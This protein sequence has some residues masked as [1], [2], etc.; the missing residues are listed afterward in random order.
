[1]ARVHRRTALGRWTV[2]LAGLLLV[3][4]V[5]LARPSIAVAAPKGASDPATK[6][7]PRG[8]GGW[9]PATP[10]K[11]TTTKYQ[12]S[13]GTG[14]P[15]VL[16]PDPNAKR[17][18]ELTDKRTANTSSFRMSDG[19]V[20]Q[21]VSTLPTH[22]RDVKGAWQSI[23]PTVKPL[24]HDGFTAGSQANSFQ[25]YFSPDA[26][27]LVRID[28]GG[29][30]VQIAAD[31][32]TTGAP[33][34]TGS[35]VSYPGA[36]PGA[37][38]DYQV[39]PESLKQT[40]VLAKAPA[41]DQSYSFTLKLG[42]GLVPQQLPDG[43]IALHSTETNSPVFT[44]P[45]PYMSDAKGD[46][47]SPYGKVYST[48]VSQSMTFD[49]GTATAHVTVK[50]DAAWLADP[51]R[52]YPV[53]I[54]PTILVSPTPSTSANTMILADSPTTNY[55]TSWRLSVGTTTTGAGR[56]LIKF[57]LP[58]IPAGTTITS[59][60]LG[61]YYD[62]T[63]TDGSRDV[64]MQALQANASW[65]ATT[66]TWS[67][68]NSI[69][70]P[71]A[72]TSTMPGNA[73]DVWNHFPVTSAVQAWVNGSPNNG[74]VIKATNEAALGLGGPRFEGSIYA[75]GGEVV[76]Y[77]KLTITYGAP[78]VSVDAPT[79]I[80]ATG[81]ELS[82][83]GYT[84]T[85]GDSANDMVE[86][87]VHR[88]VFQ[89]FT[90]SQDTLVSPV[91]TTTSRT[92]VDST[93]VPT[94]AASSDPYGNAYYYMVAVKTKGGKLIAGPTQLVRLPKAGRTTVLIPATAATTLSSTQPTAVLNTLNNGGTPE[95]WLEVGDNS[96][97]YG[98]ARSVFDFGQL[99]QVP[100]GSKI[101]DA[102]LKVWQETTTTNTSGAVYELHSL[103]RS[104]TGN[105]ATWNSPATGTAWTAAGGDFTSAAAGTVSG[106]TN[107]PNRQNF[108]ATAIVQGWITTAG[109]NHG[110]LVKLKAETSKSAQERTI[111]A[112]TNTADPQLAP[113]LVV[114]YLDTSAGTY[115]A[116][117][118]PDKM[119]PGT[120]YT[121]PVTV[122]NTSGSTWTAANERL[123]YHWDLP[124]G[125]DVT[126]TGNQ[127]TTALPADLAP[128][129]TATINAQVTPPTPA[130]SNAKGQYTLAWDMKNASNG[131]YASVT[132]GIGSLKQATGVEEP[133]SNQLGLETFYQ[134][135]T[136]PTGAGSTLYSN[137]SSGNTVW[138]Y[139]AFSNPS[140]GFATFV[141]MSYN[142]LDTT[143]SVVGGGWTVQASTPTRLGSPLDFHPNPRPTEVTF[144]DGTGTSHVFTLNASAG[145]WTS[146]PGVH[147]YL[148]QLADCGPQTTN[149]RAWEMTRPDRTQFF[150]DCEG[151]PTAVVDK[152]GNEA[153]FTY[154]D[155]QS[156]NKPEEFL[157]YI[158]DPTGRQ[159]LT[160][161]YYAKGQ[162]YSYVD[163]NGN[164]VN[165][166]HL[167]N[168]AIIDHVRSIVDISGREIDFYYTTHGLMARMVDGA[169]NPAAKTFKFTYDMTQG[170]KNVKL[171]QVTDPRG[172]ATKLAYYDP[173]TDPKFHW[174]TQSVTDRLNN[175]M[176]L[177]Y[178]EPGGI[179]N[180]AVQTVVTDANNHATTYQLDDHGRLLQ[181]VN[182][183]G[184][185][186]AVT[187]DADNNVASMTEDNGAVTTWTHDPL[188]GYPT[189]EKD[190]LAN[191]NNTA[192]TTYTYQTSLNGHV[193]D[194]IDK[195]S[196]AGRHWHFDYDANGNLTRIQDANGTAVG[197][198]GVT[199]YTYDTAG[200]LQT[201]TDANNHTTTYSSYDPSGYPGAT[202]DPLG[203]T[204]TVAYGPRGEV[205]SATDPLG[206]VTS[207]NYD[208][209]LR[210]LD[211]KTPKDQANND[212]IVTPAPV[213]DANDNATQATASNGAVTTAVFDAM[214]RLTTSTLPPFTAT[215][216]AR[217]STYTYDAVG[218]E[219]TTTEPKGNL[220]GATQGSYTITFT[221]D[222]VDRPTA[223]I[224]Y[225]GERASVTYD[226]VGNAVT[227]TDPVKNGTPGNTGVTSKIDFDL[228]H[229]PTT[230]TDAAGKTSSTGYD[231]DGLKTSTT[232][233]NGNTTYLSLN[234]NGQVTQ[235][236]VPHTGTSPSINY[237]TTQYQYDQVGN[238]VAVISPRGV[239]SGV[240]DAFTSKTS[241]DPDNRK[242]AVFGAYDPNDPAYNKAPETDYVYDAA[243]RVSQVTAP[244]SGDQTVN[245]VTKYTYWDTGWVRSST[246]PWSITTSYDYTKLGQQT[247]RTI[248]SAGGSSS[249]T[250]GWTYYPDGSLQSRTDSGVPVG[251]QVELVDNSDTQNANPLGAWTTVRSNAGTG[252][253][254]QTHDADASADSFSWNLNIPE[255]GTYQVYAEFPQVDGAATNASYTVNYDG[256]KA[257]QTVDQTK[258]TGTWVS[259]GS[260]TFSE[261][262]TG[263]SVSLA[264]NSSGKVVADAVKVVRDNSGDT[265]PKPLSFRYTYDANSN[266]VDT[267]DTS[268][269]A[270]FDDY[271][272]TYDGL[273]RMTQ[274]QEKLGGNVKHSTGYTYDANGNPLTQTHDATS[275]TFTYDVRNLLSTVVNKETA[276]DP[277]PK[278]TSYTYT[279]SSQIETE[280]KG[281]G[282]VVTSTY[283]LDDSVAS[284]VEKTKGGTLVAQ[285]TLTYDPNGN[286]TQDVS[287]TQN[288]DDKTAT[289][290]RT[291]TDTYT[292]RDQIRTVTNS[293]GNKNQSYTYD[294]AGNITAQ[295]VGGVATTSVFDRNRLLSSTQGG[296]KETYNYDPFGRT[297][298]VTLG[299]T[300]VQRYT[301]DGFDRVSSEQANTGTGMATTNFLYD[302]MDRTVSQTENAGTGSAKTTTFDYLAT[303]QAVVGESVDGTLKK[304]YQYSP[305]GE[306]LDQIVHN[307]DGTEDPTYYSYDEHTD[308]QAITDATGNAKSTYGYTAYGSSDTSQDTGVDKNV[309]S[310]TDPYNAYQF[311]ADRT[312]STTGN[313][314]TGFR[315]Y[316]PGLNRFLTQD[317]YEGALSDAGL[318]TD[319]Y[320]GNRYAFGSGNPLSNV[321]LDGH[322]S[323]PVDGAPAPGSREFFDWM[324]SVISKYVA[325][326]QA[327]GRAGASGLKGTYVMAYDPV[328]NR[329]V[330]NVAHGSQTTTGL[331]GQTCRMCGE[332]VTANQ[333]LGVPVNRPYY[334][335]ARQVESYNKPPRVV[336]PC[337]DCQVDMEPSQFKP[338]T[339]FQ[340]GGRFTKLGMTPG[341]EGSTAS[342]TLST[343]S[344][345]STGLK[346]AGRGLAVIGVAASIYDVATAPDGQKVQTAV[347][348]AGSLAG[349][350]AGAEL[351]G[352]I[353][354]EIG[355]VGGPVGVVVG[356]IVGGLVGGIVGG[357]AG[358]SLGKTISSWF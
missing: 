313:Y 38:L 354:A 272:Y 212:Y 294:L 208:V 83:P 307:S 223:A 173:V 241:Y 289:L 312:D 1:M 10:P 170:N 216:G 146:P 74:F 84:N 228:N 34:T 125:T 264:Q 162:D 52:V 249:R 88:S 253:D 218:N 227:T 278:T 102:H 287:V 286:Q 304:T 80:H 343:L 202:K 37:D 303:S 155:R 9:Q 217:T 256:G 166:T 156:E 77:P 203:N 108:D 153:D 6:V 149:A 107:D 319:P 101:M 124:D 116:P 131:S 23:D 169:G 257:T 234:P 207:Q 336:G 179:A 267:A 295:F 275:A 351:G 112:G 261:A 75:Y 114:T 215:S 55:S 64:P 24:A 230:V 314:D 246:D 239:A 247:S 117:T 242:I 30:F 299:G 268:P 172:N 91:A 65:D 35:S 25:T 171:V 279:P 297:D 133:G 110:L 224:D 226:S 151:Y 54:D 187:F 243:G 99:G 126:T 67:S 47:N 277:N 333:E 323:V 271:A 139:N 259:L 158:T 168:P 335:Q 315:N 137:V 353:G 50:P 109:S 27:S 233:Q 49:A 345:V 136:Q 46:R 157:A 71:V 44:I 232:D 141:R 42:G 310:G 213:Y 184:Q 26:A 115:Y 188:T 326:V 12:R 18:K 19:S 198:G 72:G 356:G 181:E 308:V 262:G 191:K 28:Q 185:K 161:N 320:T 358:G 29:A 57:P 104:F 285:H 145:T 103:T 322:E 194:I 93:A 263:Q 2:M 7:Q 150:Y 45:A 129:G 121:V 33:K 254:Y 222:A 43:A 301:Y 266:L 332:R 180:S 69:G 251:L 255:D 32:A 337:T 73:V 300:V 174:W 164:L 348:D 51:K 292:P 167:T 5:G 316:D 280:T 120:T 250:Q 196:P 245:G 201:T 148:Q 15:Q 186:T 95:P 11:S 68:A 296:Q 127:L 39:G 41:K 193:A 302:A 318:A 85:T 240:K 189:S 283:N 92:F 135:A 147:L 143:D 3:A 244:P 138:N 238:T 98:V 134:Y 309:P 317:L 330:I 175:T 235:V 140:R 17:V 190:A 40:V 119:V 159:T 334:S 60:D 176:G 265:Q 298:T 152:N 160:M 183:L 22:Y 61:L 144:T 96:A 14:G 177:A 199:T 328:T 178:T 130:D 342:R 123:T 211:K 276:N 237:D 236:Q 357:I 122:N 118:T 94:P 78:G 219:L 16:K 48:K 205:T 100:A 86:Y 270:L 13:T 70:G 349:A 81:A 20:Q 269:G 284:T 248:T 338:G 282:N 31:G 260:Y 273:N 347:T 288:A 4:G 258:N 327:R 197:S 200:N 58:A 76:N 306:R 229:R 53:R 154:S 128:G 106:L 340:P 311:N 111:F 221:Y 21:E 113:T 63:F 281:N 324:E 252:Y 290:D 206:H 105:Q 89:S 36:Y 97:T 325:D 62:Q 274:L 329:A 352:T 293:D 339:D 321:E 209:F 66:A 341:V 225:A 210:P 192:A 344:K 214:D 220:P 231:L 305:W 331:Y 204:S 87:Q 8:D 163:D 350:W 82:W 165:D 182:A 79:V 195:V 291:A 346:W 355:I 142:S 59:A 56:A 132:D 90:P